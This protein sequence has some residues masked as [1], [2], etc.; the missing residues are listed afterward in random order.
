MAFGVVALASHERL[1]SI[2]SRSIGS[3]STGSR[4]QEIAV[5]RY[6][7]ERHPDADAK[8]ERR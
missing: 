5:A 7:E 6:S 8:F 1:D 2:W 3:G 4:R